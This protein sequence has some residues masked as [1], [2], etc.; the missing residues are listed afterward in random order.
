MTGNEI[1]RQAHELQRRLQDSRTRSTIVP[2]TKYKRLLATGT[3]PSY[4]E[5]MQHKNGRS[6]Q[7]TIDVEMTSDEEAERLG[8]MQL[9]TTSDALPLTNGEAKQ[10]RIGGSQ[11]GI[12][13]CRLHAVYASTCDNLGVPE[14][15]TNQMMR[16]RAEH[17]YHHIWSLADHYLHLPQGGTTHT[18]LQFVSNGWTLGSEN[19]N[20]AFRGMTHMGLSICLALLTVDSHTEG[21]FW[22]LDSSYI[23]FLYCMRMYQDVFKMPLFLSVK[24][25]CGYNRLPTTSLTRLSAIQPT[26]LLNFSGKGIYGL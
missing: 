21:E 22:G 24:R 23:T 9:A 14:Y 18:L 13:P 8:K 19:E 20:P 12:T 11:C 17:I 25:H 3:A 4:D 5:H 7:E 15:A 2:T 16:E 10:E 26:M 6:H 1:L